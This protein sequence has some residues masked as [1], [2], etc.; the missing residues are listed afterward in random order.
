[1]LKAPQNLEALGE[2][3]GEHFGKTLDIQFSV[4]KDPRLLA[5]QKREEEALEIVK[6]NPVVRFVVDQF[7]GTILNCRILETGEE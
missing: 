6:S 4:G 7:D 2:L 5:Q 1:M 3:S